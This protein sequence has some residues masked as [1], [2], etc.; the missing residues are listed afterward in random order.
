MSVST[1]D[2]TYE[3]EYLWGNSE[4]VQLKLNIEISVTKVSSGHFRRKRLAFNERH[5]AE[6]WSLPPSPL[7]VSIAKG[8][9]AILS[10][11]DYRH[12]SKVRGTTP[13]GHGGP[14]VAEAMDGEKRPLVEVGV[15]RL[16]QGSE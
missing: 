8:G 10:T 2:Y 7:S 5:R 16:D 13:D 12:R 9:S 4:L 1:E 3:P 14:S 6:G 15:S 11:G